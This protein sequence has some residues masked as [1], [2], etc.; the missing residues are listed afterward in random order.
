MTH[1]ERISTITITDPDTKEKRTLKQA[2]LLAGYGIQGDG[3][4]GKTGREISLIAKEALDEIHTKYMDGLCTKR[5]FANLV[6]TDCE[7]HNQP[8]GS[9]FQVGSEVIIETRSIGKRCFKECPLV[10]NSTHCLLPK[11]VI[12]ASVLKGGQIALEDKI[13]QIPSSPIDKC[14]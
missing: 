9:Q 14:S 3:K 5:Y 7:I 4:A 12:Y 2:K 8:V 11:Q 13:H 1:I 10:Q 6:V